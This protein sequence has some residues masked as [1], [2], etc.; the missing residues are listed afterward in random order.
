MDTTIIDQK[1]HGMETFLSE[2]KKREEQEMLQQQY[3]ETPNYKLAV[4]NDARNEGLENCAAGVI[5]KIYRDALPVSDEYRNGYQTELDNSLIE[6]IKAEQPKGVYTFLSDCAVKGSKPA[7]LLCE[8]VKEEVESKCAKFYEDFDEIDPD[9]IELGPDSES[10]Q[11][12]IEKVNT[13]MDY[14]QISDVIENNVK[15][16]V[17]REIQIQKEEDEKIKAL[18]DEL[19]GDENVQTESAI[20]AALMREGM[21]RHQYQPSL[22]NGIMIGKVKEY[23]EDGDLDDEHVQKKAFFESVKEYTKFELFSTMNMKHFNQAQLNDLANRYAAR[24]K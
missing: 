3:K 23:T 4:I 19:S 5:C 15:Q 1:K 24:M 22:F 13:K 14:D 17:Q 20:E 21:S 8:A 11:D 2:L 16:T 7:Q 10:I 12:A 18:E 9:E 6:T